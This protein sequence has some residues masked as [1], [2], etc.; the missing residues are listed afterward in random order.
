ME[1]KNDRLPDEEDFELAPHQYHQLDNPLPLPQQTTH[2]SHRSL[3]AQQ[4]KEYEEMEKSYIARLA[5]DEEWS[6]YV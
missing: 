6:Q 2:N 5:E 1:E 3:L 4:N